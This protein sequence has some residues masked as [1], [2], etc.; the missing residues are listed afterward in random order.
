VRVQSDDGTENEMT[1]HG[2]QNIDVFTQLM[3]ALDAKRLFLYS[4]DATGTPPNPA[5]ASQRVGFHIPSDQQSL[6]P[7]AMIVPPDGRGTVLNTFGGI[8]IHD[9]SAMTNMRGG[10]ITFTDGPQLT[11][12]E[13]NLLLTMYGL[14]EQ[15]FYFTDSVEYFQV[16]F[17]RVPAGF[18]SWLNYPLLE[19]GI[20]RYSYSIDLVIWQKV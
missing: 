16:R 19:H 14:P 5:T 4:T 12:D 3:G 8:Y 20:T 2:Q 6:S 9:L 15:L 7:S 18:R 11:L 10:K 17:S 13:R 1:V